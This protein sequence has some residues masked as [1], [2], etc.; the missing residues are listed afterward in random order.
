M[1]PGTV[2][3]AAEPGAERIMIEERDPARFL[4]KFAVAVA[5]GETR[6]RRAPLW[7]A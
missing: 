1:H 2:G 3:E 7:L 4:E 5:S 6:A